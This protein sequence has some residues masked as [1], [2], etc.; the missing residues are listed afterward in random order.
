MIGR[1]YA[2]LSCILLAWTIGFAAWGADTVPLIPR[3]VLFSNPDRAN[4]Q[5]SPDGAWLSHLAPVEGVLNVWVGPVDEPEAA[6]PVTEDRNR[7]IRI[8]F[9]AY[10]NAHILYLQDKG[11]D[12]NWH[13]YA[14]DIETRQTRDLTPLEGVRAEIKAVSHK[15]PNEILIGLND[16]DPQYHDVYRL[17]IATGERTLVQENTQFRSFIIDDDYA[18]RFGARMTED[19]GREL[20]RPV[21]EEWVSF[22]TIGPE[23]SLTTYVEG[24]DKAGKRLYLSDSRGR[25]TAAFVTLDLDSGA[26]TL[27]AEDAKSDVAGAMLHPT[28]N[29][30]QAVAFEYKRK[31]WTALDPKVGADLEVLRGVAEGDA[32]IVDRTLDDAH[33]VVAYIPDDG[34][35]RYYYYDRATQKARYLFSN[36]RSLEGLPLAKMRPVV[37]PSRDGLELV[38]Y[39]TLPLG[40]DPDGDARPSEPLPMVLLV[41]GGP[42]ARADWGYNP[43][44]QWLANRGY[45]VL[46]VNFRGSTGFGKAFT[47]AGNLE[48]GAKMQDDLTDAVRWAEAERI[49]DPARVGILGGSYGGYAVLAGLTFTPKVFACGVDIVGPSNLLTLL[50]SVPPYWAPAIALFTTRVGDHRTEEGRA[51]LEKRSPLNYVDRIERPLLIGQGAND[52]RVKQAEADQIVKAMQQK[53]IPVTYVLFPDEGHGFARPENRLSFDAV[54][55]SFLAQ[56]L[57]GRYEPVGD[58]FQDASI[59][60]PAGA[61]DIAGIGEALVQPG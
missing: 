10:T 56:H 34:P 49:A 33:W 22:L 54:A 7:G 20:L 42:W 45:A 51:F 3:D 59:T 27:V 40:A 26:K 13:V 8:Y 25:N 4:V 43:T 29:T 52:P 19:G 21:R 47:N 23:D 5:V 44:H 46:D 50:E 16:R 61:E 36:R 11:G 6:K 48:W 24:F 57:G 28:E 30:V 60:I 2:R 12:E 53:S 39:L 31:T 58:D 41:H 1:R 32:Q 55:E 38:S 17:D 35:V 37:I 18:I 14:V 15:F 9:W